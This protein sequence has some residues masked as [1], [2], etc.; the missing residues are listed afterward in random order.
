MVSSA[1]HADVAKGTLHKG[2]IVPVG[3]GAV[4]QL[5]LCPRPGRREHAAVAIE[6]HAVAPARGDSDRVR[7]G[8]IVGPFRPCHSI[9]QTQLAERVAPA[10]PDLSGSGERQAVVVAAG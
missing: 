5:A 9:S 2:W 7:H 6:E 3:G 4:A 8:A 10:N 1:C